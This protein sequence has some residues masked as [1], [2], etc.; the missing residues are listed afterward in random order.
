MLRRSQEILEK[1]TARQLRLAFLAQ[2]WNA[3]VDFS[4][5]LMTG[6]IRN[7]ETTF[8][9]CTLKL[10]QGISP[11]LTRGFSGRTFSRS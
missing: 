5:S 7:L 1:H 6:E 11:R 8:N 3:K 2:L 9:V 4:E 10:D